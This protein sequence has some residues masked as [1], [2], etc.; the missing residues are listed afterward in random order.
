M[1]VFFNEHANAEPCAR[2]WGVSLGELCA[3]GDAV[4]QIV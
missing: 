1:N 4:A 2:P 3:F